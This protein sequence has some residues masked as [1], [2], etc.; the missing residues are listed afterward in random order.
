MRHLSASYCVDCHTTMLGDIHDCKCTETDTLVQAVRCPGCGTNM[1]RR[2][3]IGREYPWGCIA[4]GNF[5]S[6]D[7][8][9]LTREQRMSR[10]YPDSPRTAALPIPQLPD[11]IALPVVT[12]ENEAAWRA[13]LAHDY[14]S[15]G[16]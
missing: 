16:I 15:R 6:A 1:H 11:V 2:A 4:C 8:V 5:A 12:T 13:E 10:Y 14:K 9:V 3:V 7:G